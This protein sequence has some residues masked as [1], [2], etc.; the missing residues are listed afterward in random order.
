MGLFSKKKTT[1]EAP[2][3]AEPPREPTPPPNPFPE[4]APRHN[5]YENDRGFVVQEYKPQQKVSSDPL[6]A[7]AQKKKA[8]D[9]AIMEAIFQAFARMLP[10]YGTNMKKYASLTTNDYSF[11]EG[12]Y[13]D[14]YPDLERMI[15]IHMESKG[16]KVKEFSIKKSSEKSKSTLTGYYPKVKWVVMEPGKITF[17]MSGHQF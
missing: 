15:K 9:A 7:A 14:R 4:S 5:P 11:N 2:V 6:E 16:W 8:R 1:E 17:S 3:V 10:Q 13:V 12:E